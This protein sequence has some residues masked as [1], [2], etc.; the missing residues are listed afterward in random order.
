MTTIH[1]PG[2]PVADGVDIDWKIRHLTHSIRSRE[3]LLSF[4]GFA[5][6]HTP[7]APAV[8]E[9]RVAQQLEV[10]AQKRIELAYWESIAAHANTP[11]NA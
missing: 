11:T 1:S 5:T 3:K 7:E 10:I 2:A 8:I 4:T 6:P 9:A